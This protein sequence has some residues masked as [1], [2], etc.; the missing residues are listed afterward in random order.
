MRRC[1]FIS[2]FAGCARLR[3]R[4]GIVVVLICAAQALAQ[5]C[6]AQAPNGP[7]TIAPSQSELNVGAKEAPPFA[8]KTP[9]GV[10]IGVSIDLW[11]AVISHL[12]EAA[13]GRPR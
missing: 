13:A 6:L 3:A 12:A 7:E 2:L 10:W 5:S 9:D 1:E 4:T 8:M 11:R